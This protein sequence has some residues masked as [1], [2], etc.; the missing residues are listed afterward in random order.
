MCDKLVSKELGSGSMAILLI[1]GILGTPDHF[2]PFYPLVSSSCSVCKLTLMG[3]GGTV[4]DFSN[5]SMKEWKKQ[6]SDA[7]NEL[8]KTNERV[9]IVA[10][11]METLFAIQEAMEKPVEKLFLLNVPL[12]VHMPLRLLTTTRKVYTG[13]ISPKDKWRLAAKKSC[14]IKLDRSILHIFRYA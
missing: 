3:H 12:K 6:V 11:S 1:H 4:M 2:E 9:I 8:L 5:A 13:K 14:S 7:L 10:Y